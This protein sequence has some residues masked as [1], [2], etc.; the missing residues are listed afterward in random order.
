M[1]FSA[2]IFGSRNVNGNFAGSLTFPYREDIKKK[3]GNSLQLYYILQIVLT[4]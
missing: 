4:E 3:K 1:R 2:I